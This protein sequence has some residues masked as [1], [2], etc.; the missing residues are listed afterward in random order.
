MSDHTHKFWSTREVALLETHHD[1]CTP[2][3]LAVLTGH[4]IHSVYSKL[5]SLKLVLTARHCRQ[6]GMEFVPSHRGHIY[7]SKRCGHAAFDRW[8]LTKERT[9]QFE[10]MLGTILE[11]E[12]DK[13]A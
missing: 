4:S 12:G 5:R 9:A 10:K 1:I 11:R 13:G 8:I 2:T 6:C 3:E 7:C